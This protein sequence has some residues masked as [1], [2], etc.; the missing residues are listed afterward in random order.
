MSIGETTDQKAQGMKKKLWGEEFLYLL[1]T[2][3]MLFST[4]KEKI[5]GGGRQTLVATMSHFEVAKSNAGKAD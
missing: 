4:I 5:G 3:N 1:E 2:K